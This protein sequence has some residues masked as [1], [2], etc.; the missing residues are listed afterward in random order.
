MEPGKSLFDEF[1]KGGWIIPFVGAAAMIARLLST[2]DHGYS[3]VEQIKK[4]VT[5]AIAS[6]I[7]WVVL[8]SGV[9]IGYGDHSAQFQLAKAIAYGVVGVISPEIIGGIIKLG[10]KFNNNPIS[11]LKFWK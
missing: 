6:S 9:V 8:D 2:D 1:M 4:V 10:K 5:A 7:T 11:F 3:W